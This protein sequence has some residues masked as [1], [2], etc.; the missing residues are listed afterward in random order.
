M[1]ISP[2]LP[3]PHFISLLPPPQSLSLLPSSYRSLVLIRS[4]TFLF[5]L[6]HHQNHLR[7]VHFVACY[8]GKIKPFVRMFVC[9]NYL[10]CRQ[11]KNCSSHWGHSPKKRLELEAVWPAL[12]PWGGLWHSSLWPLGTQRC[13]RLATSTAA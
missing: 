3:P 13:F 1:I 9:L 12:R 11:Q 4:S 7:C 5:Q 2:F 8:N 6:H 10:R